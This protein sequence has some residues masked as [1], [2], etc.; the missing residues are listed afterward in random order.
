MCRLHDRL[1]TYYK[2]LPPHAN[3]GISN[4]LWN[5]PC[6]ST[7]MKR[8]VV[9]YRTGTLYN[10]KHAVRFKRS[11]SLVCP[12]P[13]CHHM[14]SAL[15]ILSGCQC[16]AIR[17]M[18]IERHNI[19]SRMILKVVSKGS[20]GSNFLQMDVGSA[21]RLTQHDMHITE[22]T[23]NRVIPPYLFGPSTPDQA[24]RTFNHPDAILVTPYPANPN[25]PPSPSSHR[26]LRS[27]RRNE[28]V[29]STTT[30][31][32]QLQGLNIQNRHIHLIG[33]NYCKDTRP[34]AQLEASQQQHSELCK[35]LQG[36]EITLHTIL[37]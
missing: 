33:T 3:K 30:P 35:Q 28:V 9:Q 32:R 22:Q 27:N 14:D 7:R 23:S 2:S 20:Y 16:P 10:Q 4:A 37:L 18:V 17:N 21:D 5:M 19:A 34:G 29:R 11:T 8:T 26:V 12:L 13:E 25:R 31:A 1:Y 36:A 15:H 6:V 24:R